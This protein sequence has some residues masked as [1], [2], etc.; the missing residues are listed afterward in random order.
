MNRVE[1]SIG[2]CYGLINLINRDGEVLCTVG[3]EWNIA[4]PELKYRTSIPHTSTFHR[5]KLFK[6]HGKFD[7]RFKILSDYDFLLR[8]L[9]KKEEDAYYCG[10]LIVT[11]MRYGG[12][13]SSF[14]TAR[15][16][17]KEDYLVKKKNKLSVINYY[18]FRKVFITF[19]REALIALV[20]EK[21]AEKAERRLRKRLKGQLFWDKL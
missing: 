16:K 2:I 14:Q 13:S 1:S 10:G 18:W 19:S 3:N 12:V 9:N 5:S 21:K 7:E 11:A 4:K 8:V 6:E 15:L 20:G 17:L